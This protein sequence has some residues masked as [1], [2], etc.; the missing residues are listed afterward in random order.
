MTTPK[1]ITVTRSFT[2]DIEDIRLSYRETS[3]DTLTDDEVLDLINEWALEDH[4]SP[5]SRHDL[6]MVDS[7]TGE[8]L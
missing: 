8:E 5:I 6:V 2:Y 7:D 3:G 1:R 4:T